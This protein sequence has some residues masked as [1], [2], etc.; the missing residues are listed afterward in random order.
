MRLKFFALAAAMLLL[1]ALPLSAQTNP[2][3]I[4]SGKVIDPDGLAVPGATVTLESSALQ[5]SRTAQ[6]STNGDYIIPFLPAGEYTV[7]FSLPPDRIA[8]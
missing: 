1:A 6:T 3:G 7:T 4:I 8:A 2:T 5:G